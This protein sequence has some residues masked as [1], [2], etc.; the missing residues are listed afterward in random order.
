M[1]QVLCR[2]CYYKRCV[3]IH[4][5]APGGMAVRACSVTKK[6]NNVIFRSSFLLRVD[7]NNVIKLMVVVSG[8]VGE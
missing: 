6:T 1:E 5:A 4:L 8:G 3:N 7:M 2:R